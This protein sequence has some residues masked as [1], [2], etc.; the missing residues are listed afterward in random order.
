VAPAHGLDDGGSGLDVADLAGQGA[1]QVEAMYA[2]VERD[3]AS[4][5]APVA[6]GRLG[7]DEV[8]GPTRRDAADQ[9]DLQRPEAA[10]AQ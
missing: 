10:G 9:H 7:H 2:H 3:P 6:P 1:D 5:H 4:F 8:R